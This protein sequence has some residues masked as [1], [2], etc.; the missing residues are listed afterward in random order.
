VTPL[1]DG[2]VFVIDRAVSSRARAFGFVRHALTRELVPDVTIAIEP[3]GA[4][5][6]NPADG[7]FAIATT[8]S[9]MGAARITFDKPGFRPETRALV[10]GAAPIQLEIALEPL[11]LDV[12]GIVRDAAGAPVAGTL[13]RLASDAAAPTE[14][15]LALRTPTG[16]TLLAGAA[17][18]AR[19]IALTP[20]SNVVLVEA[21]AG[22]RSLVFADRAGIATG[23]VLALGDDGRRELV[24]VS[25]LPGSGGWVALERPLARGVPALSSVARAAVS[26]APGAT[27]LS[28]PARAGDGVVWCRASVDAAAIEIA[29]A[30]SELAM[31]GAPTDA[32]GRFSFRSVSGAAVMRVATTV[33][34]ADHFVRVRLAYE[35][36]R[37]FVELRLA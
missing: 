17:V 36:R 16:A 22:D 6:K 11:P 10:L 31:V 20:L 5:V 12:E 7:S 33:G 4:Y 18:A 23:Q 8:D 30:P 34:A 29:G 26:A 19:T 37:I 24:R 28:R 1:P 3:P 21:R 25:G 32:N 14:F 2:R 27:T 9:A 13:V 15:P 35:L